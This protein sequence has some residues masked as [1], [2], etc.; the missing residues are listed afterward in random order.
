MTFKIEKGKPLP[1][2]NARYPFSE[3]E[4]GDSIYVPNQTTRGAVGQAARNYGHRN[5][6]KFATRTDDKGV[7]IWRIE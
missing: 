2:R 3:M 1:P 6:V 7:R 4:I 5:G